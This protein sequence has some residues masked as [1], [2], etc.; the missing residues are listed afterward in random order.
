MPGMSD[1][2]A[3]GDTEDARLD[4]FAPDL[5]PDIV[6]VDTD[7]EETGVGDTESP[8]TAADTC[9]PSEETCDGIDNDCDGRVDED[10]SRTCPNQRGVCIGSSQACTGGAYPHC[11]PATYE[12]HD[13]EYEEHE[14]SVDRADNDCDGRTDNVSYSTV[15]GTPDD[16]NVDPPGSAAALTPAGDLFALYNTRVASPVGTI[17]RVEHIDHRG[18]ARDHWQVSNRADGNGGI[19][20]AHGSVY[21]GFTEVDG[22]GTTTGSAA[23][24]DPAS[25]R[26]QWRIPAV[27]VPASDVV[28]NDIAVDREQPAVFL[29]GHQVTT[30]GRQ[31]ALVVRYGDEPEA[32]CMFETGDGPRVNRCREWYRALPSGHIASAAFDADSGRL[33]VAGHTTGNM[34]G[35]K[36]NPGSRTG[37][38]GAFDRTGNALWMEYVGN[39]GVQALFD[40]AYD[41]GRDRVYTVGATTTAVGEATH[42]GVVDGMVAAFD[43]DGTLQWLKLVG[44]EANDSLVSVGIRPTDGSVFAAGSTNGSLGGDANRGQFDALLARFHPAGERVETWMAGS[45]RN[46]RAYDLVLDGET[47]DVYWLGETAGEF[48]CTSCRVGGDDIFVG[49]RKLP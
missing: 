20:V 19:R 10:L 8:D 18:V 34:G 35:T 47:T 6:E 3:G 21:V 25:G 17:L 16:D 15:L 29:V 45:D 27:D 2:D 39:E 44:A 48:E 4:V 12:A 5:G 31:N 49:R 46:D 13:P 36:T 1:T 14:R 26:A 7:Y 32:S 37:F 23:R 43:S 40:V 33:F 28:V 9:L 41:A 42:G 38:V 30:T 11:S 22:S 24:F